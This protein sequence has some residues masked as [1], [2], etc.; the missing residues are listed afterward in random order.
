VTYLIGQRLRGGSAGLLA[1]F[2]LLSNPAFYLYTVDGVHASGTLF[3]L[4][5]LSSTDDLLLGAVGISFSLL[6][7]LFF[8]LSC[9]YDSAFFASIAAILYA[10][11]ALTWAGTERVT[12]SSTRCSPDNPA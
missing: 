9:D 11:T 3:Y 12:C 7:L 4:S 8:M 1:A 2:L 6:C 5:T 10:L